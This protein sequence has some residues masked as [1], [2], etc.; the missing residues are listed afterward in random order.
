MLIMQISRQKLQGGR[1][2]NWFLKLL[3]IPLKWGLNESF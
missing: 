1:I 2:L 3:M